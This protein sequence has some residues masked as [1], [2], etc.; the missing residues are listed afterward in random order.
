[1]RATDHLTCSELVEL[2]TEYLDASMPAG[3]RV[4][5]EEHLVYCPG[6]VSYLD[7]MRHTISLVG[8]L[9]EETIPEPAAQR[10]LAVFRDWK[11]DR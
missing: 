3:E 5:F 11:S 4:R 1:V 2:V 9:T 10:L 7:Q 6:C 8:R